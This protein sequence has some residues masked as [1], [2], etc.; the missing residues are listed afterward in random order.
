MDRDDRERQL[1]ERLVAAQQLTERLA[2]AEQLIASLQA[3]RG[4]IQDPAGD[5][6]CA[7]GLQSA[8]WWSGH[9]CGSACSCHA[10]QCGCV[11]AADHSAGNACESHSIV[12]WQI[13]ITHVVMHNS[14]HVATS[15]KLYVTAATGQ[16]DWSA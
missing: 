11:L 12:C 6:I 5:L 1:T 15:C 9:L 8:R 14:C 4:Q 13:D 10:V 2:G 16:R 3:G 7:V